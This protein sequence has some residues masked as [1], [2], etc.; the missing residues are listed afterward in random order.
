MFY[1]INKF[2]DRVHISRAITSE[3]YFCPACRARVFMKKGDVVSHHF[4]HE[5]VKHCDPWYGDRLSEWHCEMQ[6]LFPDYA[7]EVVI[8]NSDNSEF[9]IAD[10]FLSNQNGD[11]VFEF[12]HSS[13]SV[14]EFLARSI[15]YLNLG[16]SLVWV[17]DL[18]DSNKP[19]CIYYQDVEHYS[20]YKKFIWPGKDRLRWLDSDRVRSFL[21]ECLGENIKLSILFHT[22][23]GLGEKYDINYSNGFDS[24]RWRYVDPFAKEE[25]FIK[26]DFSSR[27][28]LSSFYGDLFSREEFVKRI[29]ALIE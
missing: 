24:I 2:G 12:Q 4:Y 26:P 11:Y 21:E 9:H 28:R 6:R 5:T 29:K 3:T 16:Y 7:R 8:Y 23:S 20:K 15:F 22:Y 1:A 10:A 27:E 17:F 18:R 25:C 13:I 19:K 14:D